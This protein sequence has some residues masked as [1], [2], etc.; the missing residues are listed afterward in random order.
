M[1][2]PW[3]RHLLLF[4][5]ALGA[6][7]APACAQI[8][9]VTTGPVDLATPPDS[10]P[11]AVL[12]YGL[13]FPFQ[14]SPTQ[15]AL[16]C[17]VRVEG[18][19]MWDYENGTDVIVLDDLAAIKSAGAVA[20]SRNERRTEGEGGE[21]LVLKFPMI[22]GFV[23]RG[24]LRADGT[25]HPHAGTGFGVCQALSFAPDDKG[26][27]S[28][29][30]KF[31]HRCEVHQFAYDGQRFQSVRSA[32]GLEQSHPM[33]GVWQIGAPGIT[34]A[35]PDGDDLLLAV[36]AS[37]DSGQ[38]AGVARW[39]RQGGKW[40]PVAFE[41]VT[42]RGEGWSEPSLV[43]DR[44]GALL[45][46]ARGSGGDRLS[47]VQVWRKSGDGPQWQLVVNTD[48][49][50]VW[51]KRQEG[52]AWG[53]VLSLPNAHSPGPMSI[54]SAA[55]G[56]P[57]IAANLPG[58]GRE[59]LCLWPLNAGRMDLEK[60]L[61]A[62]AAR[63]AFGP[64]PG[65]GKWLVDHPSGGVVRL[66]DGKWHGVVAYRVL[67]SAEH[68]GAPPAPQSGCYVEEVVSSGAVMPPWRFQ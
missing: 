45:Y 44:D 53:L 48:D 10:R 13:G 9:S 31:V 2:A 62:R 4:A 24:A 68:K 40:Q 14:V 59:T 28:W 36:S 46:S 37:D 52:K 30:A 54:G 41:A 61:T 23:P 1:A 20:I 34:N 22:G 12:A 21:R 65:D 26:H 8:T 6:L 49:V 47:Q 58:S 11:D 42:P 67:A 63:D 64:A 7:A 57:Y 15:A 16:F 3:L 50:R 27:F 5:L 32:S 17:N 25:P 18:V 39:A 51:H 43:R 35:I 56:T 66:A 33:A 19:N 55:D 38:C 29:S 60:P